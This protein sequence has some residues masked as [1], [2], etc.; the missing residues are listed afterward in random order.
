MRNVFIV[1]MPP[2]NDEAMVHYEDTIK[3]R[4]DHDRIAKYVSPNLSRKLRSIFG[5]NRIAVW[6]SRPGPKNQGRFDRMA[7]GDQILIVEGPT[8]K[9][10]GQI[11]AKTDNP[12]LAKDLWKPLRGADSGTWSLVYFIANAREVSV[13]F[14]AVARLFGYKPDYQLKGFTSLAEERLESFYARY[15]DLY[16]VLVR[17]ESGQPVLEKQTNAGTV[18]AAVDLVELQPEDVTEALATDL[19]SDHV[20]MQFTLARLGLK[21]GEKVWIPAGDKEKLRRAY[22]FDDFD[23][24]FASGIDLPHSYVE[25]IDVVWKQEFRIAAAY[26]IENSTSIYSGLLRFSDL[27]VLAPNTIYPMFVVA[28]EHRRSRLRDQLNRPT[29]K[30]MDLG[31]KVRFLSYERIEEIDRFFEESNSGLSVGLIESKA[32]R[33]A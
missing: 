22:G 17:L 1:Y 23:P 32:E 9:A 24:E 27:M 4:V 5:P 3:Q 13:P 12:A 29:F 16:S 2:G 25:N 8:V 21:A 20:R 19:V 33:V 30:R 14:A 28:P 31:S 7:L 10:I 11:A 15:D 6:G 18:D 26:E